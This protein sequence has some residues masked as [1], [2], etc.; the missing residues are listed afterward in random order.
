MR[1]GAV[2]LALLALL[3]G[4]D[5]LFGLQELPYRGAPVGDGSNDL[6]PDAPESIYFQTVAYSSGQDTN[7]LSFPVVVPPG[8]SQMMVVFLAIG[9]LCADTTMPSVKFV[10][11]DQTTPMP[12]GFVQ[13]TPCQE[14]AS[15]SEVWIISSPPLGTNNL[16]I[17]L[18]STGRSL[19]GA[20]VVLAGVN[21]S[22][23]H[24]GVSGVKGQGLTSPLVV[25]SSDGDLVVSFVAQG[26]SIFGPESPATLRYLQNVSSATTLNNTAVSTLAGA[27]PTVTTSWT[28]S[29]SDQFQAIALSLKP[30]S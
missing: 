8:E 14:Q 24:R 3:A 2:T 19:H 30:A 1:A 29:G 4:C 10:A 21:L 7:A 20:A 27:S 6:R 18:E 15:R 13:G 28:F 25:N 17:V 9:G 12:L 22:D 5:S 23:A 26:A 11:F 16:A